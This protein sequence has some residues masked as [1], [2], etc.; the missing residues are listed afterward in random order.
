MSN[1]NFKEA[2]YAMRKVRMTNMNPTNQCL[3]Q[4]HDRVC[5][6]MNFEKMKKIIKC[7]ELHGHKHSTSLRYTH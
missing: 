1:K 7:F 6:I 4:A 2:L 3:P 5:I